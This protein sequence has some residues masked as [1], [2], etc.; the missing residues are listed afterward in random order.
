MFEVITSEA[1]YLRS[2]RVA[3]F[4]FQLS[5][6][7]RGAVTGAQ[8]QQ[9]FS[10]LSQVKDTSERFLLQLEDHLDQDVFLPGLGEVVLKN[11]PAFHRAYVPYVT[12]QMYQ[13]QLMQ[14]LM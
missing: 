10:N 5:P 3:V 11:C 6:A 8:V 9:L 14:R 13:E 4:H 7:L 12:N 2:L 1:S